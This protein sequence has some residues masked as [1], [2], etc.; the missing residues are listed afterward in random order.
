MKNQNVIGYSLSAIL[1]SIGIVYCLVALSEYEDSIDLSQMGI[2]GETNEKHFEASF[3]T[4]TGIVNF[5]L[6]VWVLKSRRITPFVL[7]AIISAG[8]IVTYI[9]SRTVG[10][11]IVGVEYYIGRLDVISKVLQVLAIALSGIWIYFGRQS[12][13]IKKAV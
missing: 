2:M 9:M 6:G 10:V 7:S 12:K 1:I 5:G 3:F 11:P 8:L 13:L 4:V